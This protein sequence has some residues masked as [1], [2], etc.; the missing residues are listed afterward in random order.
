MLQFIYGW[1]RDTLQSITVGCF[2]NTNT[3]LQKKENN[4]QGCTM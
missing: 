2:W 3:Q 1:K 4:N